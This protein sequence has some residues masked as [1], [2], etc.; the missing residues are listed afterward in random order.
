MPKAISHVVRRPGR[1][2]GDPDVEIPVAEDLA[3]VP[4]I[5]KMESDVSFYSR[6]EPLESQ[7]VEKSA[8][9]SWMH[10]VHSE[11]L[12]EYLN[13]HYKRAEPLVVAS[14]ESGDL[15]PTAAPVPDKDVTD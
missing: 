2:H 15:E 12:E 5:P 9:R 1:R 10:T 13:G 11:E 6:L 14:A 7:T 8:D 3:T 4:G